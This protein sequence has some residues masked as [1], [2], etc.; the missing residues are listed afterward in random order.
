MFWSKRSLLQQPKLFVQ[1]TPVTPI[2][3]KK[4]VNDTSYFVT[5]SHEG[6]RISSQNSTIC[7]KEL[8]THTNLD[9]IQMN[10]QPI[11]HIHWSAPHSLIA[12]SFLAHPSFFPKHQPHRHLILTIN[13]LPGSV[14]RWPN[15]LTANSTSVMLSP[16]QWEQ[17]LLRGL[18]VTIPQPA[19]TS[20][21]QVPLTSLQ[22]KIRQ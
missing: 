22:Y 10:S 9:C 8:M 5:Y 4:Y 3:D 11:C 12:L 20:Y 7:Q 6:R 2:P 14:T 16:K 19:E 21:N 18:V 13:W 17:P 1:F 15:Q